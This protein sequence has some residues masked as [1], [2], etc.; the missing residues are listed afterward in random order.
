M[1]CKDL[2]RLELPNGIEAIA[3]GMLFGCEGLKSIVIPKSVKKICDNVFFGCRSLELVEYGGTEEEWKHISF[4]SLGTPEC[5]VK[6][7]S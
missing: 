4:G 7:N 1:N 2:I 6:F 3:E 5:T